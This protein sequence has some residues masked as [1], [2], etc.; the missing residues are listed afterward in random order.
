MQLLPTQPRAVALC[1]LYLEYGCIREHFVRREELLDNLMGPAYNMIS[2]RSLT[3]HQLAVLFLAF[4]VGAR[5]D[6]TLPH[7]NDEA[8]RYFLCGWTALSLCSTVISPELCTVQALLL[9]ALYHVQDGRRYD[10]D[11]ACTLAGLAVKRAIGI[12]IYRDLCS[13]PSQQSPGFNVK[14]VS[15]RR[16]VWWEAF[17][18]DTLMSMQTGRPPTLVPSYISCSYPEDIEQTTDPDGVVHPGLDRWRWML[19][20]EVISSALG[21]V[22]I[23]KSSPYSEILEL[24]KRLQEFPLPKKSVVGLQAYQYFRI[25]H[26]VELKFLST[27]HIH[28][29][30]FIKNLLHHSSNPLESP[31]ATSFT[32][33]YNGAS[34]L[35]DIFVK[36]M[37]LWPDHAMRL[38]TFWTSL[39]TAAMVVGSIAVHCPSSSIA[40]KAYVELGLALTIFERG[41]THF[42][43]AQSGLNVTRKLMQRAQE[44]LHKG[45]TAQRAPAGAVFEEEFEMFGGL[46]KFPITMP[47]KNLEAQFAPSAPVPSVPQNDSITSLSTGLYVALN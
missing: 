18:F 21:K 10:L 28:R 14:I 30:W 3:A 41:A 1:E 13:E 16:H 22:L 29:N 15:R 19:T 45:K 9:L 27:M 47:P 8:D 39:L 7:D 23:S 37:G 5:M 4:A 40:P 26:S 6:L 33:C 42:A 46:T 32:T 35:I 31:Y 43:K 12:G 11:S 25:H 2:E 20:R 17:C 36:H 24:D 38:W 44:I 34:S